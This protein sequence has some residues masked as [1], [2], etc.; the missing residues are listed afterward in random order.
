M[1]FSQNLALAITY[2]QIYTSKMAFSFTPRVRMMSNVIRRAYMSRW[3]ILG[4]L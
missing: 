1:F 3:P 4:A 2:I